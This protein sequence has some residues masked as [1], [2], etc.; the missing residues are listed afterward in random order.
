MFTFIIRQHVQTAVVSPIWTLI[1]FLCFLNWYY[2]VN[3]IIQ[4]LVKQLQLQRLPH[5]NFDYVA[6]TLFIIGTGTRKTWA[7]TRWKTGNPTP[8]Q[9]FPW[10]WSEHFQN[11][12]MPRREDVRRRWFRGISW[13]TEA[14]ATRLSGGEVTHGCSRQT[15]RPRSQ[16]VPPSDFM[17]GGTNKRR[18]HVDKGPLVDLLEC[19]QPLSGRHHESRGDGKKPQKCDFFFF[20]AQW[21]A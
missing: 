12:L 6:E 9:Q 17:R 15:R 16:C 2:A 5:G 18:G 4:Q 3:K 7:W 20:I 10:N 8:G 13:F 11:R 19:F 21:G 14:S 1:H